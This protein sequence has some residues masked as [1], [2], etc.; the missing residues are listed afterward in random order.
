MTGVQTCALPIFLTQASI[1]AKPSEAALYN[2]G[3]AGDV[4]R[5]LP[6]LDDLQIPAILLQ[7]V[8]GARPV[9]AHRT[10]SRASGRIVVV[11]GRKP[12]S[13]GQLRQGIS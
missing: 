8:Y 9:D 6:T 5:T 1:A 4:E 10:G 13:T 11:P 2:P 12:N 7:Q 3:E